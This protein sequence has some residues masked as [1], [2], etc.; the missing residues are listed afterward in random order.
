MRHDVVHY[1]RDEERQPVGATM[2]RAYEAFVCRQGW[3]SRGDVLADFFLRERIEHDLLRQPMQAKLVAHRPERM[4][5]GDDLGE[6][7]AREPKQP[8]AG[9]TARD[10]I[11]ELHG[12]VIA[13]VQ[14]LGDEQQRAILRVAVQELAHFAQHAGLARA[15]ELAPQSLA[16]GRAGEPRELQQPG[17]SDCANQIRQRRIAAAQ[18]RERLENGE[19]GLARAVLLDALPV[20]AVDVADFG[21]EALDERGLSHAGLAG[22]PHDLAPAC[23]GELPCRAQPLERIRAA[24]HR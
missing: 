16:F 23:G 24:D 5:R 3:N 18:C 10:V 13:P 12:R 21:H 17:R 11:H 8:R 7:E 19:I 15:G 6:A 4:V 22:D 20:S 14:V 2:Q 9:A 1:V